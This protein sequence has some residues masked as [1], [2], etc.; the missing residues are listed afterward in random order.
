MIA[1]EEEKKEKE[2]R[3]EKLLVDLCECYLF[4][5]CGFTH[6]LLSVCSPCL[7]KAASVK[8]ESE[9]NQKDVEMALLALSCIRADYSC[10]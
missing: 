6:E 10:I 9:E 8:E 1:E 3:N 4:L 5:S 7:L 2:K